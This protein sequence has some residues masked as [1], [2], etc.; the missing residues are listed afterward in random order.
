MIFKILRNIFSLLTGHVV[1]KFVALACM[2]FLA[3]RLGVEGFGTYETVMAYLTL[4]AT[5]AD[6]GIGTV[7]IRDVARDYA[8]SDTYFAHVLTLRMILSAGAYVL[9]LL[10]D[11]IWKTQ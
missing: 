9:L 6:N 7:T 5:F 10:F 8:S 1:S 2:I 4:F 11:S 3:R